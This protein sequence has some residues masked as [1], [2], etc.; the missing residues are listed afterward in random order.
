MVLYTF[1]IIARVE[2]WDLSHWNVGGRPSVIV[3]KVTCM[4]GERS[5]RSA[6]V[7]SMRGLCVIE[8]IHRLVYMLLNTPSTP[9]K[10]PWIVHNGIIMGAL[11]A[12]AVVWQVDRI[13]KNGKGIRM[14][15][16]IWFCGHGF[17]DGYITPKRE[18]TLSVSTKPLKVDDLPTKDKIAGPQCVEVTIIMNLPICDGLVEFLR[19]CGGSWLYVPP[20]NMCEA[21]TA[22]FAHYKYIRRILYLHMDCWRWSMSYQVTSWISFVLQDLRKLPGLKE[23]IGQVYFESAIVPG[24]LYWCYVK[25]NG[26]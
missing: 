19:M 5:A 9:G 26:I 6:C 18:R 17:L 15:D 7:M 11:C 10:I 1:L 2:Y 4:W 24:L 23:I 21:K 16:S 14:H 3:I 25:P 20:P 13:Q 12:P 22:M 8:N